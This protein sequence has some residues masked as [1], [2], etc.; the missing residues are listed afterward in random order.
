MK[1]FTRIIFL[2]LI[3][4]LIYACGGGGSGSI[5][6]SQPQQ[7]T[8]PFSTTAQALPDLEPIYASFCPNQPNGRSL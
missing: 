5:T 6:T 2:V 1:K 7:T 3:T 8:T 4:L